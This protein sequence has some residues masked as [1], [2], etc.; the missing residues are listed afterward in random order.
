MKIDGRRCSKRTS[1]RSANEPF[2]RKRPL[3][4]NS[5]F[6]SGVE[7]FITNYHEKIRREVPPFT[8]HELAI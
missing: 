4:L 7:S 8:C 1:Y 5:F 3:L 2:H 6:P